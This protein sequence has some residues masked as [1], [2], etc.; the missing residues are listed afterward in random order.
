M[1][2]ILMFV[3]R[4]AQLDKELK[5]GYQVLLLFYLFDLFVYDKKSSCILE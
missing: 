2:V 4:F 1:V 5:F 3:V